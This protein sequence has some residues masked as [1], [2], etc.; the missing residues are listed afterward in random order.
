VAA[1][2]DLA[3]EVVVGGVREC[4]KILGQHPGVDEL[5]LQRLDDSGV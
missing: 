1:H 2:G 4:R 3:N 5:V